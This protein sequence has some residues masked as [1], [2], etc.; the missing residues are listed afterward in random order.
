MHN[1]DQDVSGDSEPFET[2][3]ITSGM[4]AELAIWD[5]FNTSFSV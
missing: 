3:D 2:P 4:L 5:I 1:D